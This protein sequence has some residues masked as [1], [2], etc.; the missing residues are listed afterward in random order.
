MCLGIPGK[1]VQFTAHEAPYQ[2]A[3]IEFDGVRRVCHMACVPEAG[4][5]DYVIVHAG[6]AIARVDEHE[7]LRVFEHLASL[8]DDDGWK[9]VPG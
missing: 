7:A 1:V 4:I 9:K 2:Q 6:I 8:G 3:E 5:G